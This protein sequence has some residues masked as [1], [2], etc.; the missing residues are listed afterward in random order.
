[1]KLQKADVKGYR[2]IRERLSVFI[3]PSVTVVLGPNDHGKT[4][5][6]NALLHLNSDLAYDKDDLNWDCADTPESL[7][8]VTGEFLLSD[9][10]RAWLLKNENDARKYVNDLILERD[11]ES[12]DEDSSPP[13]AEPATSPPPADGSTPPPPPPAPEVTEEEEDY[14]DLPDEPL[15]MMKLDDVPTSITLRRSGLSGEV[16]ESGLDSLQSEVRDQFSKFFPR[17][18][19]IDPITK[20]SDSVSVK[21][22]GNGGNE[23]M[24]GIFYYAG[25]DPDDSDDLFEQSDRT[26]MAITRASEQLNKTLKE[27]WSQGKSLRF[28]LT[29][30]SKEE[31]IDLQIEDP[32]V[33]STYVRASRRSSGFTHYFSLKTI[34]HSRQQDHP[35]ESYILLFDEPGVFLHPSGQFDLLQVLETLARESQVMY[36]TH[37]LFMISKTFPTRH[38]LIMKDENGTMIDGKPYVGRW[39]NVLSALGLTLTGSILFANHVVLTE[40]DSDPIY[41]YALIQKAVKVQKADIDIN[42]LAIMST[43][44]S[45]NTDV[46]LRLLCESNPRPKIALLSD[47][48][49]GGK[50]RLDFVQTFLKDNQIPNKPLSDGT[51]I[52]DHIP[53]I[54]EVYVPAVAAYVG[55]LMVM[56]GK[57]KADESELAEKF[58]TSFDDKFEKGKVTKGVAEW[59]NEA[60][61]AI[62]EIKGK[63]SKV[64][65]AREYAVRLMD[66]PD[67]EYR[68]DNRTKSLIEWIQK[69]A[70]VPEQRPVDQRI[71]E[72]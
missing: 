57:T 24:R 27:S 55:K 61:R 58:L 69:E 11:S 2:S 16:E 17:L 51:S 37:S 59:A 42:S 18:E 36:V 49:K 10:E 44:E 40:G 20:L 64:G 66:F 70:G 33:A 4:N 13:I 21:E 19:L 6:L 54:R 14:S 50:D 12:D 41:M 65:I 23:F 9:S 56:A 25:L 34:L 22:L 62:G 1:M 43:S 52:E 63:P 68:H 46:L 47:G 60:A 35:A 28:R 39:Q 31:R 48:D 53:M 71:L 7:P 26:Q 15:E 5:L 38:R 67:S 72:G 30:N 29:H 32:S 3:E 45:Q 8:E